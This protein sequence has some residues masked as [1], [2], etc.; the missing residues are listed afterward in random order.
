MHLE[1]VGKIAR[2]SDRTHY[3]HCCVCKPR[4]VFSA[5][6]PHRTNNSSDI[7]FFPRHVPAFA[8]HW[9][10]GFLQ[11]GFCT[12]VSAGFFE[13]DFAGACCVVRCRRE[14]VRVSDHRLSSSLHPEFV[15][16][17][18]HADTL[19]PASVRLR[20]VWPRFRRQLDSDEARTGAYRS[21]TL[22]LRRLPCRLLAVRKSPASSTDTPCRCA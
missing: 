17:H 11:R 20:T 19:R 3:Y 8:C 4:S 22:S 14:T 1:R 2:S 18:P 7:G 6:M 21:S 5:V 10:L 15:P 13:L 12:L 9:T 16:G